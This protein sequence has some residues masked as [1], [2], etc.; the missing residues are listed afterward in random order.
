VKRARPVEMF[1]DAAAI[2]YEWQQFLRQEKGALEMNDH[3]L[4]K[5]LFAG[6]RK[7]ASQFSREYSRMFGAPPISDVTKLRENQGVTVSWR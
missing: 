4:I 5:L 3:Q 7:S 1:Q 6:L 2:L